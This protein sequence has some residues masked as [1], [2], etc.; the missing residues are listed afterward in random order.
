[1]NAAH[2][3]E[4]RRELHEWLAKEEQDKVL[5]QRRERQLARTRRKHRNPKGAKVRLRAARKQ[6]HKAQVAVDHRR[7][8]LPKTSP[9]RA[10]A[11]NWCS[12]NLYFTDNGN[13]GARVDQ[14]SRRFG[15]LGVPWC[16]IYCG[17]ALLAGGVKG[18]TSR[19][20][21]VSLIEDDARAHRRP[22]SGWSSY[23]GAAK[24]GDLV[25]LFG[26]GVHVE[27]VRHV[28]HKRGLLYTYGGNTS[29]GNAGSQ[30][31]G[32]GA[33]PRVRPFSVVHG[34]AHVQY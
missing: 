14:L 8:A 13:R 19:I 7:R 15:F 6:L 16:G 18:V 9:G 5:V 20:A 29:S 32:G 34:I 21:A 22:F 3:R 12:H 26:R 17:N 10:A 31:N 33:F 30:S 23:A 1:M 4:L 2:E 11:L 24:P 28:D 27:M 25:V